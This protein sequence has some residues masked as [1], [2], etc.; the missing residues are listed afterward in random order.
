MHVVMYY[1]RATS[2]LCRYPALYR[3]HFAQ[4]DH[5]MLTRITITLVLAALLA[6]VF[7]VPHPHVRA[8]GFGPEERFVCGVNERDEIFC[9]SYRGMEHGRWE[10][11]P[12]SLRQVVIRQGHL[13]GVNR[14]G[15]IFY[16]DDFRAGDTHW[17]RLEG[18]AKEISEGHGVLCHVNDKDQVYCADE[19]ID[20]PHP[21]WHRAP[22]GANLKFISVN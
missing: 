13:W 10:K 5:A 22:D 17:I 9:T 1:V 3:Q 6:A 20:T 19:G 14:G 21:R 4:G 8:Q 7:I 16:S 12:G 18:R 15:E 11:I 2:A